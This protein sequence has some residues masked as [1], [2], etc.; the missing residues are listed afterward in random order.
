MTLNSLVEFVFVNE[1]ADK[2]L[3]FLTEKFR[4][5]ELIESVGA[6]FRYKVGKNVLLSSICGSLEP[7]VSM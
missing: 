5:V 6:F 1:K 7:N 4:E 3:S 2:L